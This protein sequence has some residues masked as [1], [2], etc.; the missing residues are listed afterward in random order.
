MC[1]DPW[2]ASPSG[3]FESIRECPSCGGETVY[4]SEFDTYCATYG[5]NYSPKSCDTCDAHDCDDSC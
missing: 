5:C 4:N 2:E 1:C 3:E